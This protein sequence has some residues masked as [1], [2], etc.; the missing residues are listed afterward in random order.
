MVRQ[1][2]TPW[3]SPFCDF[4]DPYQLP[5]GP[6]PS[7]ENQVRHPDNE[8]CHGSLVQE[9]CSTTGHPGANVL[10]VRGRGKGLLTLPHWPSW[11]PMGASGGGIENSVFKGI[12]SKN[13]H[14]RIFFEDFGAKR[15]FFLKVFRFF[16]KILS[17]DFYWRFLKTLKTLI[18]KPASCVS[19]ESSHALPNICGGG[20]YFGLWL[21]NMN[22]NHCSR[23]D[24]SYAE[25]N[26]GIWTRASAGSERSFKTRMYARTPGSLGCHFRIILFLPGTTSLT[27][28]APPRNPGRKRTRT[29][30]KQG[31]RVVK[32]RLGRHW[33]TIPWTSSSGQQNS[34]CVKKHC[35]G[36][37]VFSSR[38][39]GSK[40]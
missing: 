26:D 2:P 5:G 34:C 14:F 9:Q 4:D 27:G 7:S 11:A 19:L 23:T 39:T 35:L 3:P 32:F 36:K 25:R 33:R 22:F 8:R 29:T 28:S 40:I 17:G 38:W 31:V 16:K 6:R 12:S 18:E 20:G 24:A 15:S 21:W 30:R 13:I 37:C 10:S 1:E